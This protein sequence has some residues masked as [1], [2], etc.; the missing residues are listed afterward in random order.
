MNR[1]M[2][3]NLNKIILS[4]CL[5]A[6]SM[7]LWS[8]NT[9][10]FTN[11]AYEKGVYYTSSVIIDGWAGGGITIGVEKSYG[12]GLSLSAGT[13]LTMQWWYPNLFPIN[14]F[15]IAYVEGKYSFSNRKTS[16]YTGLRIQGDMLILNKN[17]NKYMAG[18]YESYENKYVTFYPVIGLDHN[19][20][21]Y[22]LA[23][24]PCFQREI[25][26]SYSI[27]QGTSTLLYITNSDASFSGWVP[28]IA[29]GFVWH[30]QS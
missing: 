12:T 25:H 11:I 23:I 29:A 7:S 20:Y 3:I 8:Q 2:I 10:D 1:C 30:W 28:S 18:C 22:W 24:G 27:S 13:G 16:L 19:Y 26:H 17:E 4:L 21:S 14:T 5:V 9:S 6:S 15:A